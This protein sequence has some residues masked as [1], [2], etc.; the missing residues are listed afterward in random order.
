MV[1]EPHSNEQPKESHSTG[2]T[3]KRTLKHVPKG[4]NRSVPAA[5]S[6][7]YE[8]RSLHEMSLLP[9]ERDS[10]TEPVDEVSTQRKQS[11][12][13]NRA[14][15]SD[16]SFLEGKSDGRRSSVKSGSRLS[17]TRPRQHN[18]SSSEESYP[19]HH[20]ERL[21]SSVYSEQD[22]VPSLVNL[23]KSNVFL[24][25]HRPNTAESNLDSGFVGSEGTLKSQDFSNSMNHSCPRPSRKD[26]VVKPNTTK[27]QPNRSNFNG[28]MP[29]DAVETL[30]TEK[31]RHSSARASPADRLS[32]STGIRKMQSRDKK[33]PDSAE[34]NRTSNQIDHPLGRLQE[35]GR[36]TS[37]LDDGISVRTS[38]ETQ[39]DAS[40]RHLPV[41][42]RRSQ[43]G[44]SEPFVDVE[45]SP[46]KNS[47]QP[48]EEERYRR[49]AP[50]SVAKS[51][52]PRRLVSIPKGDR[53]SWHSDLRRHPVPSSSGDR[54]RPGG[55]HSFDEGM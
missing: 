16:R 26:S 40:F 17:R 48:R 30:S 46:L 31:H 29:I 39:T 45:D 28:S 18:Y 25:R 47:R 52:D 34:T 11:K 1:S 2:H 53:S 4:G 13:S 12:R 20:P 38:P 54:M 7:P 50:S 32:A 42:T 3:P 51:H 6:S 37:M 41:S 14:S 21:N 19:V 15:P 33:I 9:Q 43:F 24:S 35:V 10:Q 55:E 44:S 23:P 22:K 36:R 27:V 5:T 8:E 49:S